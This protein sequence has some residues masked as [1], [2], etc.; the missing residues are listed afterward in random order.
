MNLFTRKPLQDLVP[1]NEFVDAVRKT[2]VSRTPGQRAL[3]D[4]ITDSDIESL[5]EK[6][7]SVS[8]YKKAVELLALVIMVFFSP[9]IVVG[10]CI[11]SPGTQIYVLAASPVLLVCAFLMAWAAIKFGNASVAIRILRPAGSDRDVAEALKLTRRVPYCEAY[12]KEVL[13]RRS[14]LRVFDVALLLEMGNAQRNK[15]DFYAEELAALNEK[16]PD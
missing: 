11:L 1:V 5:Q 12:R 8:A 15:Y 13:S 2:R 4:T 10:L 6:A 9:L 7:L 3:L 14:L 16:I